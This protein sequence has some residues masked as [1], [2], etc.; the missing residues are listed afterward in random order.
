MEKLRVN[1]SKKLKE[2]MDFYQGINWSK[3]VQ[4]EIQKML[5]ILKQP[6]ENIRKI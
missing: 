6:G 5:E 3:V 2:E 1:I 4:K